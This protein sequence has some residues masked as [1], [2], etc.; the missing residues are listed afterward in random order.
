[1]A[2]VTLPSRSA[3]GQDA[4]LPAVNASRTIHD[5][6][7]QRRG[8]HPEPVVLHIGQRYLRPVDVAQ[9]ASISDT[10]PMLIQLH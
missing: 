9:S 6:P 4:K 1:M 10:I 5:L 2:T 8:Y 7:K 3:T